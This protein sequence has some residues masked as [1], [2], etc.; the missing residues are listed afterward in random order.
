MEGD[1]HQTIKMNRAQ[2]APRS[3][4][5]SET[6]TLEET[7]VKR[8]LLILSLFLVCFLGCSATHEVEPSGPIARLGT[9]PTIDGIFEDGEWDDAEIVRAGTIEQ[10]RIKHD[11]TNLYFAL[12]AGGGNLWFDKDAGLHVLHWSAQLGSAK[13]VKLD[14]L[15]QV[16]D[17]PFAFE[18]WKL[19]DESPAVINET[20]A[21]YLTENGWAS[22]IAPLGPKMQSEFA[23]SFDWLGVTVGSRRFVELPGIH[24]TGGLMLSRNDPEAKEIMAMSIEERKKEFPSLFWPE[25]SEEGHPLNGGSC[26]DTISTVPSDFGKIWIDLQE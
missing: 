8:Q 13:H 16:L 4:A 19:Q 22:N 15:K 26:P 12:N 17:K 25:E 18:L 20:L 24:I 1:V 21:A 3:T 6:D 14:S 11:S 7:I 23:V 9:T 5:I 2:K 10:F